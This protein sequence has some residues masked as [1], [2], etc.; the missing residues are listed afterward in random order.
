MKQPK[1]HHKP[2]CPVCGRKMAG[3][4]SR[5]A[6]PLRCPEPTCAWHYRDVPCPSCGVAGAANLQPVVTVTQGPPRKAGYAGTA[7]H[8]YECRSCGKRGMVVWDVPDE[9]MG[10]H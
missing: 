3:S 2:P 5:A 10:Y 6:K 8:P 4:R 1:N 7:Q 9:P